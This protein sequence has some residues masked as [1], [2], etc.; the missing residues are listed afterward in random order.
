M[1]RI[2]ADKAGNTLWLGFSPLADIH[3]YGIGL[4]DSEGVRRVLPRVSEI[5]DVKPYVLRYW[6]SEFKVLSPSKTRCRG[7]AY[8]GLIFI[9]PRSLL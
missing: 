4:P 3:R 5:V 8:P 1:H 7:V 6:E 9:I 2:Y